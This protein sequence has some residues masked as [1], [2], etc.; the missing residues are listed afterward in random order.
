MLNYEKSVTYQTVL[1]LIIDD[2]L[3]QRVVVKHFQ[4]IIV[5]TFHLFLKTNEGLYIAKH[6]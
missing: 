3:E 2:V 1:A 6:K 4:H 5:A